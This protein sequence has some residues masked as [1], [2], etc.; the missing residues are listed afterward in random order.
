M[1][2]TITYP[3]SLNSDF[4]KLGAV[5]S[6]LEEMRQEHNRQHDL[7]AADPAKYRG[8]W[9]K[10]IEIFRSL[11]RP[12]LL[13]QNRLRDTI[14]KATYPDDG[15]WR[16]LNKQGAK[17][18]SL[19]LQMYGDKSELKGQ[20][21]LATSERLEQLKQ[22]I[23]EADRDILVGIDGGI[24]RNNIADVAQMGADIIVTGSAVFDGKTPLE[25]AKFMISTLK[26]AAK[27]SNHKLCMAKKTEG[28]AGGNNEQ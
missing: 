6:L 7:Y 9:M 15:E 4:N 16:E 8:R 17:R 28:D 2:E 23:H 5:Y 22:I 24:T 20:P 1:S 14:R 12:L 21:T 3:P 11:Q 25:N 27:A 18:K 10:Y 13:E 19:H 26:S